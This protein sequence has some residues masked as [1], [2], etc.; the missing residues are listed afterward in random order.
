MSPS[1]S[2]T[3]AGSGS[4]TSRPTSPAACSS[5]P[6]ARSASPSASSIATCPAASIPI[7]SSPRASAPTSRRL[8]TA[9]SYDVDEAYAELRL[10]L[11][12]DTPFFHRLELTGAARYSDYSTSGSTTTFSAGINWEPI[13]DLLFRGT[14]AEGFRAPS[15]GELFGTPSRFDQEV[16]DP[17]SGMTAAT[18]A[19]IRAN[20][21]ADG[22]PAND[23]YV[24]LNAQLPVVTGGNDR[25]RCRR[26]R[27]AGASA[28]SGGRASCRGCRSRPIITTSRSTA[29]S[30]RSTPRP[31]SAAA[32]QTGDALSCAA[33]D[34][35]RLGPGHPDPRPA[36]EHRQH[37]DRRPRPHPDLPR[38][39]RARRGTFSLYLDQHLPVQLPGDGA[40]DGR[41][42]RDRPRRHRAGQPRPGLPQVQVDRDHRL[43]A[44]ASS[45][46]RSPAA[47]SRASTEAQ[48]QRARLRASTPTSSCAGIRT[49]S[50]T[51]SASRSAPTTCSTSIRRPA[52]PAAST[53]WTRPPTTCR[54]PSSTAGSRSG[55]A[56]TEAGGDGHVGRPHPPVGTARTAPY[57][58][59]STKQ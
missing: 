18:P 46:P 28:W 27:K 2:A 37:R 49:G 16:V 52:S 50:A 31:C 44:W 14:W 13:E 12:R 7:R 38:R 34:R 23:S 45:A 30:R 11:L 9:G 47:T 10:P 29:R 32:P 35:S 4:G 3:A 33:I 8:P 55:W 54:A 59:V 42:H 48:R 36:A 20:C 5:C 1:P 39:R 43:D 40:G 25:S 51:A 17:C 57:L 21:V 6:A 24:Q 15:I 22:V 53:I 26:A 56:G 58:V 19:N 41:L